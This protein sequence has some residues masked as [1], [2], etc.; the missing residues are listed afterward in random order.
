MIHNNAPSHDTLVYGDLLLGWSWK[1][2]APCF[3][4]RC[5]PVPG[6]G[7]RRYSRNL[8]HKPKNLRANVREELRS[9]YS[10]EIPSGRDERNS[11]L[12]RQLDEL[13]RWLDDC[14][15]RA[16][17]GHRTWKRFRDRQWKN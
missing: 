16:C 4:F 14:R 11:T 15:P 10:E 5:S 12:R 13:P 17:Y 6:T 8:W 1:K 9:K 3:R 2:Q 7:K